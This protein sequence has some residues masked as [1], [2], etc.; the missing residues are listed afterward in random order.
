MISGKLEKII[1]GYCWICAGVIFSTVILLVGYLIV[2][3]IGTVGLPLIF[4][5]T[6]PLDAILLRKQVFDGLF[7]AM[8]GTLA[9]IIL[10]VSLAVPVGIAAGI[11]MAEYCRGQVK[12]MFSLMFDILAGIPSIVVGLFGFSISVFLHKYVSANIYPCL[13]ISA[14]AL[15]FLVL[16]YL[17][18]TTQ[19]SLES[20]PATIRLTAPALGATKL[21]NIFYVLIPRS[22]SGIMSGVILAIGRCAEDTAVIMMTGVVATSGVPKSL[23]SNYEALPFYI[24]YISSQYADQQALMKGYGAAVILLV[25]C[26]GL[27]IMAYGIRSRLSEKAFSEI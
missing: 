17:I 6:D 20:L 23:F 27:F 14:L 24:Y 15:A 5:E 9:L 21:Q 19:I 11:Y 8:A 25:I 12:Q 16:P 22:L 7:P 2:K 13:L 26:A 1:I 4:G 18:R 3:G 10:S